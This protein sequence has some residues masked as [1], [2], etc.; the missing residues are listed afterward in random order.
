MTVPQLRRQ[1]RDIRAL[2]AQRTRFRL[3]M[4]AEVDILSEGKLDYPDEVLAELDFVIG[5]IHTGFG[6]SEAMLTRRLIAA[7]RNPYV[8]L[9]AHPTGRLMGQREGYPVDLAAVFQAAKSTGTALEINAQPRRIDLSDAAAK[10]A[11]EAG[12]MLAI[13]TDTHAVS[14]LNYM[15]LGLGI[16]RRAW[17]TPRQLLNCMP[18]ADLLAWIGAKRKRLQGRVR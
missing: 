6:Q 16:A 9:I 2:N 11:G 8:T 4:G 3:L 17:L 15:A 14:Q 1:M 13:S 10:Q 12:V 7:M 18:R 5:S